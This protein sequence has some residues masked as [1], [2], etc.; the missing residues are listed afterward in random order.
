[1]SRKIDFEVES[2]ISVEQLHA[3][4]SEADYWVARLA[5]Y[6]GNGR[7]DEIDVSDGRVRVVTIQDLKSSL[8]PKPFDK[9]YPRD[10]KL[11][12]DAVWTLESAEG[13][14]GESHMEARGARGS[15]RSTVLVTPSS[16]GASLRFTGTLSVKVP[17]V[18][19]TIESMLSR[20]TLD[21][22][23]EMVRFTTEWL[24]EQV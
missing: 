12:Q 24:N 11:V 9:L 22:T 13:L 21:D 8:L 6:G 18:G 14:R 23:P 3:A 15:S 2:T 17:V 5:N 1:M 10:L 19:G 4:Y 16:G 7:L 20:Q